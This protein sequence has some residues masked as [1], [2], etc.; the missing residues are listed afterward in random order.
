MISSQPA[1]W[2]AITPVFDDVAVVAD[3]Q[4][5]ATVLQIDLHTD[6][7]VGM[8]W[9]VVQSDA[10]AEVEGSFVEGLPVEI[11]LQVMLQVHAHIRAGR[12][13]PECRAQLQIVHP[14]LDIFPVQEQ[15]QTTC[16]IEV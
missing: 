3:E 15:I 9:Q 6:Q 12:H 13:R 16:M 14:D 11:E 8:A 5:C 2:D 10:L 4:V 7:A 1:L